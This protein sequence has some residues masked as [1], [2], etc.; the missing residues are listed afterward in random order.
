[1]FNTKSWNLMHLTNKSLYLFNQTLFPT[2]QPPAPENHFSILCFWHFLFCLILDFTHKR[3]YAVSVFHCLAYF[4]KHNALKIHPHCHKWQ[5]FLLSPGWI[6]SYHTYVP[7]LFVHSSVDRHLDCFHIFAIMHS[8]A[9]NL[10]YRYFLEVLFLPP[11][12][13]YSEVDLLDHTV[14]LF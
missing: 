13:I 1:M 3:Y 12:D 2:L 5:N 14:D 6:V 4:T 11:L 10:E 9:T 7:H 8:A